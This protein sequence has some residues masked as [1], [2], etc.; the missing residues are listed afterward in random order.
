MKNPDQACAYKTEIERLKNAG[1]V[2]KLQ[3][4]KAE[5]L[6]ESWYIP[7]YMVMHNGKNRVVYNCLFYYE[8]QNL[9][10]LLLSG[11]TF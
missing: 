3:P 6:Q 8:G 2:E 5:T 10:E 4:C 9:N 1:Y 7:H 11:P